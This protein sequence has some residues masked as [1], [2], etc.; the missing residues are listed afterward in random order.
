M[1][2]KTAEM[3]SARV[4]SQRVPKLAELRRDS[5]LAVLRKRERTVAHRLLNANAQRR[6]I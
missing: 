2:S 5:G 6:C 4:A 3:K 1:I